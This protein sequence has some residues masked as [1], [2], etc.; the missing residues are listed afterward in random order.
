[1]TLSSAPIQNL[2]ESSWD[3]MISDPTRAKDF[4]LEASGLVPEDSEEYCEALGYIG[5]CQIYLGDYED[6]SKVLNKALNIISRFNLSKNT[7][8]VNNA[9]GMCYQALGRYGAALDHFEYTAQLARQ[10]DDPQAL[11][12]PL[13][14]MASL[15]FEM[16]HFDTAEQ[17]ITEVIGLDFTHV[18]PD[19]VVEVNLLQTQ[20]LLS[21]L[22]FDEAEIALNQTERLANDM[23]FQLAILRCKT[24]RGR[25]M[26]LRG[27]LPAAIELL[28][29]L[30]QQEEFETEGTD[31]IAT[32]LELAKALYSQQQTTQA[33]EVLHNCLNRLKPPEHSPY[34]LRALEQIAHGYRTLGDHEK[35]ADYLRLILQIERSTTAK[36][37]QNILELREFKRIQ[38]EERLNQILIDRENHLLKQ[39]RDRLSLL[40]D[41][42]HQ[43]TMTLNF[44]EL[45]H[46]LYKILAKHLDVHFVSLL[47]LHEEKELLQFRFVIDTGNSISAAD[48]PLNTPHSNSVQAIATQKPVIIDDATT[49]TE[50]NTIG[51]DDSAPRSMLFVPLILE[52][53]MLGVFSMQSQQASR[54]RGDEVQFMVAICKFISIAVSNILSHERVK[55]LNRILFTEKQAI[56]NAQE[57]IAHMAYHDSLTTLPNRQALEEL[58][59]QRIR[60][61]NRPFHLVYIDLDGFKPVNDDYGHRVGDKVLIEVSKRVNGSLRSRDFAARVGGDEFVLVVD[62]FGSDEDLQRFLDRLLSVIEAPINFLQHSLRISASIG[63]AAYPARGETL[64]ELMHN[65]DLAMYEIKRGGKGGVKAF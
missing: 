47:T 42:A 57:R 58:V 20:I 64:D 7:R 44:Q 22:R 48:I 36:Q 45:G 21:S 11:M 28:T 62:A 8:L 50:L 30:T 6:A 17:I 3:Q 49:L 54:F 52:D 29:Q 32:Y 27:E 15:F 18:L 2:L 51:T 25:L 14:N 59:E 5:L 55:Q 35:E 63:S 4:A 13:I 39:S 34:R 37:T 12:P 41:I 33:L 38:E 9:L 65:A 24:L 40:N 60:A 19:N 46:R 10:S 26:R 23:A 31:A 53:E 1:M 56:E 43:I 16:D 61:Q